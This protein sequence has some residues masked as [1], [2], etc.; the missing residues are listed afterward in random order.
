MSSGF[1]LQ[2]EKTNSMQTVRKNRQWTEGVDLMI[3]KDI[4]SLRK[5]IFYRKVC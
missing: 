5:Y 4:Y 3:F 2:I 1:T